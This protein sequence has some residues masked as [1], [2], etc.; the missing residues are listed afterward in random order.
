MFIV[1]GV[2]LVFLCGTVWGDDAKVQE[3]FEKV[4]GRIE[5][6]S[7]VSLDMPL[8]E[9]LNRVRQLE[10]MSQE[11]ERDWVDRDMK[12]YGWLMYL[13][14]GEI[15]GMDVP[16]VESRQ[17]YFAQRL[18]LQALEKADKIQLD[19]YCDILEMAR[20]NVGPD[21]KP[22]EGDDWAELRKRLAT[23]QLA[24]WQRIE[25]TIDKRWDPRDTPCGDFNFVQPHVA[26]DELRAKYEAAIEAN[27]QKIARH[28]L[29]HL[30]R[31]RKKYWIPYS[32]RFLIEAYMEAPDR[33]EELDALLKSHAVNEVKRTRILDAVKNKKLPEDLKFENSTT[34]P[35]NT[36][37]PASQP[38]QSVD[39]LAK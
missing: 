8:E 11:I 17:F 23:L 13:L 9:K 14:S 4:K 25:K 1:V 35:D 34:R 6:L 27:R 19:T 18:A 37:Q 16:A 31:D 36:T 33:L 21:G 10:A 28:E 5:A 22:L 30:A 26:N 20:K 3:D 7:N 24:G 2:V 29:Q 32:E 15:G 12:R 39:R 38:S